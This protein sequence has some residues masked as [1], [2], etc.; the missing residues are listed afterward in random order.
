[1]T[2]EIKIY[3]TASM[4]DYCYKKNVISPFHGLGGVLVVFEY[5]GVTL[6]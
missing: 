1:M 6:T 4:C 3:I 2:L 5:Q